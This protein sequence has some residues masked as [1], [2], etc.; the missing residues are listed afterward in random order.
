V[1]FTYDATGRLTG[2]NDGATLAVYAYDPAGRKVTETVNFG[3]FTKAH[4]YAYLKNGLKE[5]FTGPDNVTYGYVYDTANRLAGVQIP[6]AGFIS[7]NDYTWNRPSGLTL[8]GGATK[9]LAYDPLMRI[10]QITAKDPAGNDLLNYAYTHDNMDNI[11]AKTTEHGDYAYGYD[12]LHRL[13]EATL[14]SS[15][16]IRKMVSF[17]ASASMC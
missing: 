16:K 13:T 2:Y 6:D 8:P 15:D 1:T 17:E 10:S 4:S 9:S 14:S 11:T 7:V 5:S 12:D 3:T